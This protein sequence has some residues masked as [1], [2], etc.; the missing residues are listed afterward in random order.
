[1]RCS[2]SESDD[3]FLLLFWE[4]DAY[5]DFPFSN[6]GQILL[7]WVTGEQF[8]T[9]ATSHVWR[10]R[11][12]YSSRLKHVKGESGEVRFAKLVKKCHSCNTLQNNN[13]G[14]VIHW[15]WA[16]DL[17]PEGERKASW[18]NWSSWRK[19]WKVWSMVPLH[20]VR[21]AYHGGGH[22]QGRRFRKYISFTEELGH[23]AN[24]GMWL[25][26]G[27][28]NSLGIPR[29]R[30]SKEACSNWIHRLLPQWVHW[31]KILAIWTSLWHCVQKT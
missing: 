29:S 27:R 18:R 19:D 11:C 21:V 3:A 20:K 2:M 25:K 16:K 23:I 7:I 9:K 10:N 13:G 24:Q 22:T 12:T 28:Q 4:A 8:C 31:S 14:S 30:T 5:V 15:M 17:Y 26:G 1:M 6:V